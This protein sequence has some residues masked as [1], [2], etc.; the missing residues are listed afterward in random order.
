VL[1]NSNTG[2]IEVET[3]GTHCNYFLKYGNGKENGDIFSR[4]NGN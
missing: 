1:K 2:K 4:V 3:I